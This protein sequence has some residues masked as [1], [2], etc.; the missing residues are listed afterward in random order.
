M[1]SYSYILNVEGMYSK[2]LLKKKASDRA[3][4]FMFN[5]MSNMFG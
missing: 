2:V 5:L 4:P 1:E 3:S